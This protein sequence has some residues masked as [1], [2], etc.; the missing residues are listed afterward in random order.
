MRKSKI[1]CLDND[2]VC[3]I[4]FFKQAADITA[5]FIKAIILPKNILFLNV[6]DK[7]K[8]TEVFSGAA[9]IADMNPG[10]LMLLTPLCTHLIN[11]EVK[12]NAI[13]AKYLKSLKIK[14]S[15]YL[16]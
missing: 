12:Y 5:T 13:V 16:I 9:K 14:T 7:G 8:S 11:A 15:I 10:I 3:I 4:A 2:D 1:V 6:F